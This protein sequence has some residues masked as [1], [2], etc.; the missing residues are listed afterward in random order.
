M[1]RLVARTALR[2]PISR[3]RS[4]TE[5]SMIFIFRSSPHQRDHCDRSHEDLSG[6]KQAFQESRLGHASIPRVGS[7]SLSNG[8]KSFSLARRR[9]T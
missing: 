1:A 5:S 7:A 3:V 9:R 2:M 8:S 4:F 6:G